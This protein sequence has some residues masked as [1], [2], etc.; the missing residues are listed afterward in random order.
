MKSAGRLM[1][2]PLVW[3]ISFF[4]CA[5]HWILPTVKK[6]VAW[7]QKVLKHFSDK[8]TKLFNETGKVAGVIF[9]KY[10][11]G[12][13]QSLGFLEILEIYPSSF[14]HLEKV[15]EMEVN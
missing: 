8:Q 1:L 9:Y 3:V 14:P 10:R 6:P 4:F 2:I 12:F 5:A 13:L 7:C 11:L 15:L